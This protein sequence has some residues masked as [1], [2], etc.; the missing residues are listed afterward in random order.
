[1]SEEKQRRLSKAALLLQAAGAGIKLRGVRSTKGGGYNGKDCFGGDT[2]TRSGPAPAHWVVIV[3]GKRIDSFLTEVRALAKISWL[4]QSRAVREE[5]VADE[6]PGAQEEADTTAAAPTS[7]PALVLSPRQRKLPDECRL[8]GAVIAAASGQVYRLLRIEPHQRRDGKIT[9]LAVWACSSCADCGT[10]FECRAPVGIAPETRRCPEHRKPGKRVRRSRPA[11]V[12]SE[13][14]GSSEKLTKRLKR[15]GLTPS[16]IRRKL[17][18]KGVAPDSL[19]E[20]S[21]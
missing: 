16:R 14:D 15:Q 18:Q 13:P 10:Q 1:M 6:K 4:L 21:Q 8:P 7:E 9:Q 3:N 11:L 2:R 5:D 17:A 19:E 20:P 12:R